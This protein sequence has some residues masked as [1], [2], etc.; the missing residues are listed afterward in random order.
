MQKNV[1]TVDRWIRGI[2]GVILLWASFAGWF[3]VAWLFGIIG[4][5]LVIT[6]IIGYC[7]IYKLFGFSSCPT[8]GAKE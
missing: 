4:A 6:G 8:P 2:L 3:P 7:G 1:G 5:I